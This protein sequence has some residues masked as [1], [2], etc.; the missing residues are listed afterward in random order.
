MDRIVE[1]VANF[2]AC[3]AVLYTRSMGHLVRNCSKNI[4]DETSKLVDSKNMGH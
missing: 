1:P 4:R 2:S 3:R